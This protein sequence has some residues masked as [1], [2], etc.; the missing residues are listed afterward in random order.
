MRKVNQ[1]N[2]RPARLILLCFGLLFLLL[3]CNKGNN[4]STTTTLQLSPLGLA[5][6]KGT[7]QQID[8]TALV[9][10]NDTWQLTN[11]TDSSGLV[12][13]SFQDEQI[14]IVANYVGLAT[15]TYEITRADETVQ[16]TIYVAITEAQSDN[17]SP[18]AQNV[19]LS[20]KDNTPLTIELD[21]CISDE[22]GDTLTILKIS[23]TAERFVLD[24]AS[25]NYTPNGFSGTEQALY[26]IQD[27]QGAVATG[28]IIL[29][30]SSSQGDNNAPVAGV[31][32]Y[33][34]DSQTAIVI[35][36]ADLVS[37][38]DSDTIVLD[39]LIAT[40]GRATMLDS[41]SIAY[42][43]NG[44][45]GQDSFIYIVKDNQGGF[46]QGEINVEVSAVITP[47]LLTL[48]PLIVEMTTDETQTI[49]LASVVTSDREWTLQAVDETNS[50]GLVQIDSTT[51]DSITLTAIGSGVE[52]LSYIVSY[53][54]DSNEQ[55]VTASLII[56]TNTKDTQVPLASDGTQSMNS[57][58][59]T[60][61]TFDLTTLVTDSDSDVGTLSFELLSSSNNNFVQSDTT[62]NIITYTPNGF[63]G[64]DNATYTVTD[65]DGNS[66]IA[67]LI[68]TVN[69]VNA[70]NNAPTASDY[71]FST[72]SN[73]GVTNIS[74]SD[75]QAVDA[76]SDALTLTLWGGSSR[77]TL[78]SDKQSIDYNPADFV[79]V[80]TFAYQV[81][82]G[83]GGNATAAIVITVSEFDPNNADPTA[84]AGVLNIHHTIATDSLT[85]A[86]EIT[87]NTTSTIDDGHGNALISD[88][89]GDTL[90]LMR[91]TGSTGTVALHTDTT[92]KPTTLTWQWDGQ[93]VSDKFTYIVS[94]N[95]GGLAQ[96]SI[97][98]NVTNTAPVAKASAHA[99]NTF[100]TTTPLSV[101]L[102]ENNNSTDMA[103]DEDGDTL[104]LTFTSDVAT[105]INTEGDTYTDTLL[106]DSSDTS[107]LTLIYTPNSFVGTRI[108][109][110]TINDGFAQAS[111]TITLNVASQGDI[112]ASD[113]V[114]SSSLA[115]DNAAITVDLTTQVSSST[116]RDRLLTSVIG[117]RL[118]DIS[119]IDSSA[120][121]LTFNYTP[122]DSSYGTD[123]LYYTVSDG[124]GHSAQ[125]TVTI[126]IAAPS[127]PVIT[128]L[129]IT[130]NE[131][132]QKLESTM[133]CTHCKTAKTDYQ[134]RQN[135]LLIGEA[136][137]FTA[138]LTSDSYGL[139]VT[140]KNKYCTAANV[141]VN[142]SNA[143]KLVE[144]YVVA[145][146]TVNKVKTIYSTHY[147]FAALS[148]DDS[149]V[150]WG[151]SY[152]GGN[153]S[154]VTLTD[155]E[156]I[157]STNEA[158]VALKTD[159]TVVTWGDSINGG[160]S[161]A[162]TTNL[163]NIE[164]IYS[165]ET[166][167]AALKTDGTVVTWGN[168]SYG[169]D[170]S[171]VTL[172][173]VETIYSTS[174]A[175]AA[176]KTDGTVVTWGGSSDGGDSSGVTL[177][178]VE[179]IYSNPYAF[180]ALKTDGSVVTWGQLGRGSDS[181]GVTSLLTNVKSIYSTRYAFAAL[182][183]NGTVVTWGDSSEGGDGSGVTLTEVESI[184][185]TRYAFA[186]LKTDGTVVTWGNSSNGGD[187]SSV[188]LTNI[189]SI[190]S[191]RYAFAALKTDGTVVTW[192]YSSNGG[193]SSGVTLTDVASIYSTPYAFAALKID[194]AVI[195]WGHSPWGGDSS[196]VAL[197]K[198][199]TIYSTVSAFAAL[200][201]NGS[202]V[203]WGRS[204]D[205]GDS[206]A[207]SDDLT[208]SIVVNEVE[209]SL[210]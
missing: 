180:A 153:S 208:F 81:S 134:W 95:Q 78:S 205:G 154:G 152:Y 48:M 51:A 179:R 82:D 27:S 106:I 43:P 23:Q 1:L 52:T 141:G 14:E 17:T 5:A 204:S 124:E 12:T 131:E 19:A 91:V 158:F 56:A 53:T 107:G 62:Q 117:A 83:R 133:T 183:A 170:S 67:Q 173:E 122:N 138:T 11:V 16:S 118:G 203:T 44:F 103:Y 150:T 54:A 155:V 163:I 29:T 112:S 98:V 201:T 28:T 171:S 114:N 101:N 7:T 128:A 191:A 132:T 144:E 36:I 167:F 169:G 30:I 74:L 34:T 70:D 60:S 87:L 181:S 159:G 148:T 80:D 15:L 113:Y 71:A 64:V 121:A 92:N 147:A 26:A 194:G 22:D 200:K 137:N 139:I 109:L 85:T 21:D 75:L 195:T 108:V 176:L 97:T 57:D 63:I 206:S 50:K 197:T 41:S 105:G 143:C 174:T 32:D 65:T 209:N 40:A 140:A 196:G 130:A 86:I 186:A 20:G 94:D 156:S 202:V 99:I 37:D 125:A 151:N 24:G 96:N 198:V 55:S 111:N 126:A 77:A 145:D 210:D 168:P 129:N 4:S 135:N 10:S 93:S 136:K 39:T 110:Y 69:D 116:G 33:S 42:Q 68:V 146:V 165:T 104:T 38:V 177:T 61:L 90:T 199:N 18:I 190:Y 161:S 73:A 162:V 45:T 166:A 184:Y 182:K 178:D 185:S 3:G 66:A 76:D 49:S 160:D 25:L 157:Y 47:K 188:T 6:T 9:T 72:Y 120:N 123:T 100:E 88:D 59:T 46:A 189:E 175:F 35:D 207:V 119:N 193:D 31:G 127:T 79:G 89:D 187:S 142:G 192:G 172:I 164:S 102:T 84:L 115:M 2:W 58:S 149:V 8:V 13:I